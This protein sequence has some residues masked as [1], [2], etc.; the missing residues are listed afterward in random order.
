MCSRKAVICVRLMENKKSELNYDV[1]VKCV[2]HVS[3][4][5]FY[6]AVS[7][8]LHPQWALA[9]MNLLHDVSCPGCTHWPSAVGPSLYFVFPLGTLFP[10]CLS[11]FKLS[12]TSGFYQNVVFFMWAEYFNCPFLIPFISSLIIGQ[13]LTRSHVWETSVWLDVSLDRRVNSIRSHFYLCPS[14]YY[15]MCVSL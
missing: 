10:S 4:K 3:M 7:Q 14:Y 11:S 12:I 9:A 13:K 6:N 15:H 8:V 1:C 5:L 2:K